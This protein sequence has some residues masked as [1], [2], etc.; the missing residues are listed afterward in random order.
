M[1]IISETRQQL[2]DDILWLCNALN[3]TTPAGFPERMSDEDMIKWL[4][5]WDE[6]DPL[7]D[8]EDEENPNCY[9]LS[10]Y[11]T[12][13]CNHTIGLT[14]ENFGYAAGVLIDGVPFEAETYEYETKQ[15]R[16]I[17]IGIILPV[18]N[19]INTSEEK[20]T[21]EADNVVG[22]TYEVQAMYNG[23]LNLGM[24]DDGEE[25]DD[26]IIHAYVEYIEQNELVHFVSDTWNGSVRYCTDSRGSNL[27]Y[28]TICLSIN[29]KA[30]AYTNLKLNDFPVRKKSVHN[31]T[32]VK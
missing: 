22:F 31:L 28:V 19:A 32:L 18:L 16:N 21:I 11:E 13:V 20:D 10:D 26:D 7:A 9:I 27:A 14:K 15:G 3:M 23:V 30:H 25:L 24:A 29:G 1:A 5:V 2:I 6:F 12:P 8:D 4:G 17:D